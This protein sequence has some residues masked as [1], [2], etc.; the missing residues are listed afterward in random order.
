MNK[1]AG[2]GK[3]IL[4][5]IALF[6]FLIVVLAICNPSGLYFLS[7]DFAHVPHSFTG[8][9]F[10]NHLLRPFQWVTL[11]ADSKIWGLDAEGF[12]FTNLSVH[13]VNTALFSLLCRTLCARFA[14][15]A[16]YV[17]HLPKLATLLF[18][19]YAYHSEPVF[20]ILGRGGSLA[21][22][23]IQVSILMYFQQKLGYRLL[24]LLSFLVGLFTYEL[25]WIVPLLLTA[26]YFFEKLHFKSK[27]SYLPITLH[28]N[29]LTAYLFYRYFV[30]KGTLDG[31]ATSDLF[32]LDFAAML[33]KWVALS[34]RLFLPPMKNSATFLFG[35]IACALLFLIAL[36]LLFR[37]SK[38][39][40]SFAVLLISCMMICLIPV[41]SLG[42]DTHDTESE[43]VI[44]PA[45]LFACL[46][47]VFLGNALFIHRKVFGAFML[48]MLLVHTYFLYR[49]SVAYRY[50][51]YVSRFTIESL[52]AV[53]GKKKL[54]LTN[55]PTQ[56][57]GALLF[58]IG[59]PIWA[60]GIL[61]TTYDSVEIKSVSE[62]SKRTRLH[63]IIRKTTENQTD[64][65]VRFTTDTLILY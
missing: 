12:H 42:I 47:I 15:K 49:S 11:W 2:S 37:K 10:H 6:V 35:Y 57:E 45:T 34:G 31:Y 59:F 29:V 3:A 46:L 8:S 30:L 44:Y 33:H 41:A 28:W 50:A 60:P 54:I 48:F 18:F 52:N 58:R 36:I 14:A 17:E 65:H 27:L 43:R 32:Q 1:F 56:F 13:L 62:I 51:S 24:G 25:T 4:H 40:F 55:L 19:C 16:N 5:L 20:W 22:V 64:L 53:P 63:R 23:F 61:A 9:F 39:D 38:S 26:F 21:A 7:D